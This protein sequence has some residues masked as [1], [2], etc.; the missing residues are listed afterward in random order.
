M[1]LSSGQ[2]RPN[3]SAAKVSFC[4]ERGTNVTLRDLEFSGCTTDS[5]VIVNGTKE[6]S[7]VQARDQRTTKQ[8][9]ASILDGER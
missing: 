2:L 6:G 5:A 1:P 4:W 9:D 3:S 7:V 8:P